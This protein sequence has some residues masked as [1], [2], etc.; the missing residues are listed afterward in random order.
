MHQADLAKRVGI[1]PAALSLI[2]SG[3]RGVGWQIAKK[4]SAAIGRS[5]KWWMEA[6]LPEIAGECERACRRCRR[7]QES[8]A[9]QNSA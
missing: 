2:L 9:N 3:K 1:S 7:E 4:L 5:A 8:C 6:S